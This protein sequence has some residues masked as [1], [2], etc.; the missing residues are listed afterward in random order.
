MIEIIKLILIKPEFWAI[1]IPAFVAILI[2][3]KTKKSEREAEWRKVKLKLYLN[4]ME[5]LSG[6]TDSEKPDEGDVVFAKACNDL[7]LLA[8]TKRNEYKEFKCYT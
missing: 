4:F 6:I 1:V 5:S 2:F 7:H 8:S 3:S